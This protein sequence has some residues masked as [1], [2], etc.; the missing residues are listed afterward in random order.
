MKMTVYAYARM[1]SYPHYLDKQLATLQ[2]ETY[3]QLYIEEFSADDTEEKLEQIFAQLQAG[4]TLLIFRLDCLG[5][6]LLQ[7]QQFISDLQKQN[8]RL[9]S[10]TE[11]LDTADNRGN[12]WL[13]C[14]NFLAEMERNT[15]TE[16]TVKGLQRAREKGK[17]GGRPKL[18]AETVEKIRKM[19]FEESCSLRQI[20]IACDISIGSV[21][22]YVRKINQNTI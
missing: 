10:L 1:T 6:T 17:V 19:Y 22:K 2:E 14:L 20:A 11:K 5:K 3:D 4:D 18:P 16:N 13:N 21:H 8:V 12:E 9:L 7:L 15:A